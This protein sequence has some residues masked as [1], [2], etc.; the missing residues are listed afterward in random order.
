MRTGLPTI[1][2]CRTAA[3]AAAALVVFAALTGA[4]ADSGRTVKDPLGR[5]LRVPADPVRVVALAPSIT[6]IV[7]ALKEE[8]RL[9]GSANQSDFPPA[10]AALPK[11]GSYIH[12]DVERIVALRPDLCIGVKD[13]N[14]VAAVEQLQSLGIPVFAVDPV[15]LASVI[16]TIAAIGDLLNAAP[17]ARAV[18]AD[19]RARIERVK[20]RVAQ[21]PRRPRIFFQLAVSPMVSV[22][23][24][25]FIHDLIVSAGGTNVAQGSVPYPRFSREQVI[26]LAPEVIVISSMQHATLFEQVKAEWLQWPAIPAVARN[27][28]F[29]APPNTFDRP[30][31]RL[32][33]SLELLAGYLHPE[34]FKVKP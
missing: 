1:I 10:A 4:V 7:Y 23:N 25:T 13:G 18:T 2:R 20:A 21:T 8:R 6:E 22:G 16:D 34:L 14:P 27:A 26:A 30:S 5:T 24:D 28:V 32:V 31:P 29:I 17:R 11:V 9:V 15:N 19:M 3:L 12:L 33:D